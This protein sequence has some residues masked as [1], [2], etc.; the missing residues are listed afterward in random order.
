MKL[1]WVNH[2]G[3]AFELG[4]D[5]NLSEEE[6]YDLAEEQIREILK[7]R[8]RIFKEAFVVFVNKSNGTAKDV[9]KK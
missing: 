7:V 4:F 3:I 5:E 8:G 1:K 6:A 2:I 9:G